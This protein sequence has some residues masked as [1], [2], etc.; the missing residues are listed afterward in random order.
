MGLYW[1]FIFFYGHG[2]EIWRHIGLGLVMKGKM[3]MGLK[4]GGEGIGY[5]DGHQ[6]RYFSPWFLRE[7]S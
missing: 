4:C 2:L 1:K 7:K 5:H 6:T 3:G